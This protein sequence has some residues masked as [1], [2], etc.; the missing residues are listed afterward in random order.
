MRSLAKIG[1]ISTTVFIMLLGPLMV[2]AKFARFGEPVPVDR[3]ITNVSKF[4]KEHP[5][6]ARA[7]YTLGRLHSLA[8]AGTKEGIYVELKDRER[9]TPLDLPRFGPGTIRITASN[10]KAV[11]TNDQKSHLVM[12]I[13]E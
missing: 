3:L 13:S 4:V 12:S 1:V 6:D 8:F 10:D 9:N 5:N 11:L 7:H 2:L